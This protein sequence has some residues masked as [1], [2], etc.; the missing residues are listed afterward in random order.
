MSRKEYVLVSLVVVL[1]GLYAVYFTDWFRPKIIRI[2]HST[3]SLREAW[4]DGR[5]VDSTGK[6]ALGNVTFVLHRN[7]KLTSVKV[8]PLAAYLTNKY[9][10]PTWALV[11]KPGSSPTDGFAY[12]MAVPG[13]SPTRAQ[14][15]PDPLEPG[16]EYRLMVAAGAA[17]GEHDFTLSAAK[18]TRR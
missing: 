2:T 3:R 13:M 12:G 14:L 10:L 7:Y 8:V 18:N 16:V 9:T 15:D 1:V 6:Q 4:S 11:S 5:R 17:K